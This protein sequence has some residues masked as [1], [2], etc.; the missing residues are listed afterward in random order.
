MAILEVFCSA[1]V[2]VFSTLLLLMSTKRYAIS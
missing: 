2:L 1:K